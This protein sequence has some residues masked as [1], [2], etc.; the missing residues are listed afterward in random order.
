MYYCTALS[1]VFEWIFALQDFINIMMMMLA[2]VK[3]GHTACTRLRC[4]KSLFGFSERGGGMVLFG[5][6]ERGGKVEVGGMVLSDV[7]LP[8]LLVFTPRDAGLG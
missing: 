5:F 4:T 8:H 1:T 3:W 6:S 2:S 7:T